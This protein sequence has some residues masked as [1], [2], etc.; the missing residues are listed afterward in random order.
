MRPTQH[1]H[2][3]VGIGFQPLEF[4][5]TWICSYIYVLPAMLDDSSNTTVCKVIGGQSTDRLYLN[6]ELNFI[7]S[8]SMNIG[9]G[10][11]SFADF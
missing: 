3:Q 5:N 4:L 2:E 10:K 7:I 9:A 11:L 6:I 1:K 8:A